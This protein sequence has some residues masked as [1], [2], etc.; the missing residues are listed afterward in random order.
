MLASSSAEQPLVHTGRATEKS[1]RGVPCRSRLVMSCCTR[2]TN[3]IYRWSTQFLVHAFES[4][5]NAFAL[6][7]RRRHGL[8]SLSGECEPESVSRSPQISAENESSCLQQKER[9]GRKASHDFAFGGRASRN[10]TSRINT[11]TN[12]VAIYASKSAAT[13]GMTDFLV[14]SSII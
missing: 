13:T 5:R 3:S 7:F 9:R 12:K 14:K 6:D 10:S 2:L 11:I 1:A 8:F 4:C